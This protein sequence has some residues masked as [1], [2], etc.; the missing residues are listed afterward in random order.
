MDGIPFIKM[1]GLGND[2]VIVDGRTHAVTIGAEA[3]RRIA[4]RRT[5]VGCDQLIVLERPRNRDA[6]AFMA[7]RNADGGESAACGNATRCVA[8]LLMA[9][10]GGDEAVIETAAGLL[11]G[12]GE[13]A[14]IAVDMGAPRLG[15]RDIPLAEDVDTLHLSLAVEGAAV[16]ADPAACSMGN[17]HATFFVPDVEAIDI[18][19]I[20]PGLEH[21]ALFPE[22]ANIGFAEVRARGR[23]RLRV[24]E[25]GAGLTQACATGA[26]AAVVN[27]V[28]RGLLD[29]NVEC[30]LD[31]G[32]LMVEWRK[33]DDHVVMTGPVAV[34]FTGILSPTL[35]DGGAP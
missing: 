35:L 14:G 3:A 1:N 25:R 12:R 16:V 28:R 4:E 11:L 34:A 32:P 13:D 26:C 15:W 22:R 6:Q 19:A 5:G 21:H 17:P 31:G 29:R 7:I 23:I 20:G 10:S 18:A 24:W 30:L 27:G 2:F 9:E 33:A 8:A